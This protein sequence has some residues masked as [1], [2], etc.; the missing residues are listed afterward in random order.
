M[1]T[2]TTYAGRITG[3][4]LHIE[5]VTSGWQLKR[6]FAVA[7]GV[8]TTDNSTGVSARKRRRL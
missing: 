6:P 1:I 7:L 5:S 2:T 4:R 8:S 3:T